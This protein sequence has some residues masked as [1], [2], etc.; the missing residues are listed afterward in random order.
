MVVER[1]LG[2][3]EKWSSRGRFGSLKKNQAFRLKHYGRPRGHVTLSLRRWLLSSLRRHVRCQFSV[4][5][6]R[7]STYWNVTRSWRLLRK[8]QTLE[9]KSCARNIIYHGC[10][11]QIE[12]SVTRD[13]YLAS[14]GKAS[15]RTLQPWKILII[16]DLALNAHKR[17]RI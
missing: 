15:I 6:W 11:L 17:Y 4:I 2:I 1:R 16:W 3:F 5:L 12:K 9:I 14:L 10:L 13:H 7:T 8:N